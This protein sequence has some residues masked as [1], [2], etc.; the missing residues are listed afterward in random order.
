[1]SRLRQSFTIRP[2]AVF[3]TSAFL[4]ILG[5]RGSGAQANG[6]LIVSVRD[7]ASGRSVAHASVVAD[8]ATLLGVTDSSGVL[9]ARVATGS[10]VVEVKGLGYLAG[11]FTVLIVAETTT[12][13]DVRLTQIAQSLDTMKVEMEEPAPSVLSDFERRRTTAAHGFFL[14]R[15]QLDSLRNQ[16]LSQV[17]RSRASGAKL[18]SAGG[19]AGAGEYLASTRSRTVGALLGCG[20]GRDVM[21]SAAKGGCAAS[22]SA[23]ACYATVYV[24]GLKVFAMSSS[25]GEPPPFD[26]RE[27]PLTQLQALEY[28]PN[29]ATTPAELRDGNSLCGILL[30]WHRLR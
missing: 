11:K 29:P 1:M 8:R 20:S 18:V 9:R 23:R 27:E 22:D 14:T 24:D 21:R 10:H 17:L 26:L 2:R 28:Y 5:F 4:A 15:A 7:V 13:L 3:A 12:R 6:S 25:S 19:G 16:S 30:L